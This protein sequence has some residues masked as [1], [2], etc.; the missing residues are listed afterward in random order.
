MIE[1]I[2]K[3]RAIERARLQVIEGGKKKAA[4]GPA[5]A[6]NQHIKACVIRLAAHSDLNL[7]TLRQIARI[8]G[9][10]EPQAFD[11]LISYIRDLEF[12]TLPPAGAR[13]AAA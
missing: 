10:T 7:T 9:T 1:V 2:P 12:R 11:I 4:T 3:R 5:T 6:M 13:R 8:A